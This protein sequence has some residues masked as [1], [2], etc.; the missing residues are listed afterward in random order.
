MTVDVRTSPSIGS[1][2]DPCLRLLLNYQISY[3]LLWIQPQL[4]HVWRMDRTTFTSSEQR[5]I[6]QDYLHTC[7]ARPTPLVNTLFV[8]ALAGYNVGHASCNRLAAYC[9]ENV[10]TH[11]NALIPRL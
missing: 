8:H 1:L 3:P 5:A 7:H 6:Y 2:F 11:D 9:H 4:L 10:N